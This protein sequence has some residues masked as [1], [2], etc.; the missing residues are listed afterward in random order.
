MKSKY[1]ISP[2]AA[3]FFTSML[4]AVHCSALPLLISLGLIGSESWMHNHLID[5]V[6]IGVGVLIATYSLLGDFI[7]VHRNITPLAMSL[8]GFSLLL[9]GMTEHHGWMLVFSVV[10]GLLVATSHIVNFR[11]GK[12]FT[13]EI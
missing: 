4:C 6:V 5:W 9:I 8:A 1:N 3:G 12:T 10:G 11:K 2:D 13:S 7:K